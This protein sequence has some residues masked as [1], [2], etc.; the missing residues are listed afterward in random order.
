[1]MVSTIVSGHQGYI[2][3]TVKRR[4]WSAEEKRSICLQ[5]S[6][7]GVSVAQVA[8]RY[9]MNA[10]LIFKWLR[11]DRFAPQGGVDRDAVFLPVEI[12]PHGLTGETVTPDAVSPIGGTV[13]IELAGGHRMIAEGEFDPDALG[14]LLKVWL[15]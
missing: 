6:A 4:F 11:D 1:M 8:Q 3:M 9:S 7:P 15:S 13:R 2:A 5:A 12:S 14:R 10:N